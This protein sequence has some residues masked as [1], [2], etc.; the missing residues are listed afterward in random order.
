MAKDTE[1]IGEF[2]FE[3]LQTELMRARSETD[4]NPT[5]GQKE[6][7]NYKKGHVNIHGFNITIENP[8]G[9]YRSGKDKNGK[10][11][12]TL[13]HNDYGYFTRTLGKDGD[14][15][16]VF[17]GPNLNSEKIF[18][19]DQY[20]GG[21]FDETKVM[22][23]FNSAAEAKR[24]YLSNYEK[25]WKGFKYIT[26]VSVDE[27]KD[28]LYNGRRQR[29]AFAK[30]IDMKKNV[31]KN[32]LNESIAGETYFAVYD[33]KWDEPFERA[34]PVCEL[35]ENDI[36][37]D[38]EICV[39]GKWDFV[40]SEWTNFYADGTSSAKPGDLVFDAF[41][42]N[43]VY[44]RGLGVPVGCETS[45]GIGCVIGTKDE[46]VKFAIEFSD[47]IKQYSGIDT[48]AIFG[49]NESKRNKDTKKNVVRVNEEQLMKI[50]SEC[51]KNAISKQVNED[52]LAGV[53][54]AAGRIGNGVKRSLGLPSYGKDHYPGT[55]KDT[56]KDASY[57]KDYWKLGK[58]MEE[59][60]EKYSGK[61]LAKIAEKIKKFSDYG[62][63]SKDSAMKALKHLSERNIK[64]AGHELC[65]GTYTFGVDKSYPD[66]RT[67]YEERHG[68]KQLEN[69]SQLRKVVAETVK[70]VME[71]D[72]LFGGGERFQDSINALTE[73]Y[74][75]LK[76]ENPQ[77]AKKVLDAI[78]TLKYPLS[79]IK[80]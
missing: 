47:Y 11:W 66:T 62:V 14:A 61:N 80:F 59:N 38:G 76:G 53:K 45:M 55:I 3:N 74:E 20:V 50:I 63:I 2:I 68:I 8:K 51:V 15:V 41:G 56:F 70:K 52:A 7:G 1:K 17:I 6:A 40:I 26:E 19:I 54:A 32:S 34:V 13:M 60:P 23:G 27:F 9:S 22:L 58:D 77:A 49:M 29:K 4:T 71:E 79:T 46:L 78:D 28:W 12:K 39:N 42:N 33:N 24:A 30:Y 64:A 43:A 37:E 36:N 10:P 31:V 69:E 75:K 67:D 73:I 48:K 16:D 18:P 57:E 72:T 21:K 65:Y 25:D 5:D 35:T 44:R